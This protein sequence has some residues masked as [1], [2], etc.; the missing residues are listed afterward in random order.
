[1]D[2]GAEEYVYDFNNPV[3]QRLNSAFSRPDNNPPPP[4]QGPLGSSIP[5]ISRAFRADPTQAVIDNILPQERPEDILRWDA[6]GR[7][8]RMVEF[9]ER[10]KDRAKIL[11]KD[12]LRR[13]ANL[14]NGCI[15]VK[16]P[17]ETDP[18][19]TVYAP[20]PR[21]PVGVEQ[22]PGTEERP[23]FE[24]RD[25]HDAARDYQYTRAV[26]NALNSEGV[27]GEFALDNQITTGVELALSTLIEL[28]E[29]KFGDASLKDFIEDDHARRL[30]AFLVAEHI[31]LLR[32]KSPST[33]YKDLE[34]SRR[35]GKIMEASL[36]MTR[37]LIMEDNGFVKA[38]AAQQR[39]DTIN[40]SERRMSTNFYGTKHPQI[41]R[42]RYK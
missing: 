3:A 32:I 4:L 1:M 10:A 2:D 42:R 17:S 37:Q 34:E 30:M 6:G 28:D 26:N 22:A 19:I 18:V 7:I 35:T 8:E 14:V 39:V 25:D 31:I 21:N 27:T 13:F 23:I 5:S 36:R 40:A 20:P 9:N 38:S 12:K 41:Y 24:L 33:Y 16:I 11:Y 29:T 15:N